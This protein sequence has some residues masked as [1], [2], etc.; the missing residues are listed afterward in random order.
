MRKFLLFLIVAGSVTLT[1][2]APS[3]VSEPTKPAQPVTTQQP[4]EMISSNSMHDAKKLRPYYSPLEIKSVALPAV[5]G[6]LSRDLCPTESPVQPY[7]N[8]M[9]MKNGGQ[10]VPSDLT[11]VSQ[12]VG[13]DG[14]DDGTKILSSYLFGHAWIEP[15]AFNCIKL[16]KPG[17]KL[18]VITMSGQKYT[19]VLQK[20][21]YGY[22]QGNSASPDQLLENQPEYQVNN[23]DVLYAVACLRT[24]AISDTQPTTENVVGV[25]T[26]EK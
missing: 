14:Y 10:V 19:F 25:F 5:Q 2:C 4:K 7:T 3:A 16:L 20:L 26:R 11:T 23:L 24:E 9:V 1:G 21:I 15:S 12:W 22:K 13:D 18:V 8:E 6:D 17:E